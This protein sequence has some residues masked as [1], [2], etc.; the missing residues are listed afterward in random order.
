MP[1]HTRS[2]TQ[3]MSPSRNSFHLA[4][5]FLLFTQIHVAQAVVYPSDHEL[6]KFDYLHP[7]AE[8]DAI[9]GVAKRVVSKRENPIPLILTNSCSDTLWPGVATQ[10][11]DGPESSGFE[12]GPGATRNLTV[13]P[14]WA[15]RVWGRT[16]CTVGNDTATCQTG[17]C[18][19]MLEC[20]Y[21]V[22]LRVDQLPLNSY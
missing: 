21:S 3:P 1:R 14:T 20:A 8:T 2:Y 10:A 19:G 17:D 4:A 15:G 6:Y 9:D 11:G 18:F 12:L 13:G 22:G 7:R 5:A 16:N